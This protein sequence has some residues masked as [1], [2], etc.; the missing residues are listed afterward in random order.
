MYYSKIHGHFNFEFLYEEVV[1]KFNSG[2]VFVEI[3]A[4]LGKSTCFLAEKVIDSNKEIELNIIDNWIGHPSDIALVEEIKQFG[5]IYAMFL[6]NMTKAG[7]IDKLNIIKGDSAE[8]S[9]MFQ[10]GSVD[11]V[12]IDA[13]HDYKSVKKD[14]NAW[15]PKVKSNGVIAGHDYRNVVETGVEKAVDELIGNDNIRVVENT[16]IYYKK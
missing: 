3:G 5:D 9:S 10:N 11:F 15:I 6:D 7:I 12:F 1:D 8:T 2:S 4:Y 13:A 14:I 16:W